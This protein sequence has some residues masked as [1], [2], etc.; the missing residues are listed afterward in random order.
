[1]RPVIRTKGQAIAQAAGELRAVARQLD[2]LC[3][4]PDTVSMLPPAFPSPPPRPRPS[5]M[6]TLRAKRMSVPAAGAW[7]AVATLV[8]EIVRDLLR[9][10]ASGLVPPPH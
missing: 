3:D 6:D 4:E 2:E 7:V 9:A 5:L 8:I 10:Y 1:M